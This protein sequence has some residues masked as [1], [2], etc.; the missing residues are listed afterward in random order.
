MRTKQ[1]LSKALRL[2]TWLLNPWELSIVWLR[3]WEPVMSSSWSKAWLLSGLP[4]P[5][6]L[7]PVWG[8]ASATQMPSQSLSIDLLSS[9]CSCPGR[10]AFQGRC[11]G[12][13]Q[14]NPRGSIFYATTIKGFFL[15]L[16]FGWKGRKCRSR[17]LAGAAR[18]RGERNGTARWGAL[19]IILWAA[20]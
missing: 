12:L 17:G 7:L 5:D 3:L 20:T 13:C 16:A 19:R 8:S 14:L 9:R 10:P 2:E 18:E 15:G 1:I 4:L 11:F 6:R